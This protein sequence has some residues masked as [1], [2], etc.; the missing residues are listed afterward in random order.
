MAVRDDGAT[1]PS[2]DEDMPDLGWTACRSNPGM[3]CSELHPGSEPT[4][5]SERWTAS[6]GPW[7]SRKACLAY[8]VSE[9]FLLHKVKSLDSEDD[10]YANLLAAAQRA[11]PRGLQMPTASSTRKTLVKTPLQLQY[12]LWY[13]NHS[14]YQTA[15]AHQIASE[16]QALHVRL[17]LV[18]GF[19]AWILHSA[20]MEN[21]NLEPAADLIES[22]GARF[23]ME[24]CTEWFLQKLIKAMDLG[25][26]ASNRLLTAAAV[27]CR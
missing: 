10:I 2:S 3:A 9:G 7:K 15:M 12:I 20:R 4:A 22:S 8:M 21:E 5:D 25:F 16:M 11:A 18:A 13:Q 1:D 26:I 24:I 17:G 19:E 23:M 6:A 14:S 27:R